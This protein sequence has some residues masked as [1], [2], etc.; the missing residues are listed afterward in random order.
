MSTS[1]PRVVALRGA[2]TVEQDTPSAIEEASEELV[3][4]LLERNGTAP[5]ELISL[6]FTVTPD[7][8]SEFP[9]AAARKMG[10][11]QVPLLCCNEIAVPGAL[12]RCIRV[13]ATLYTSRAASDLQHAYLRDA[14]VLRSDLA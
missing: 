5:E 13:L 12:Q 8:T 1:Q 11:D 4:E 9:A 14:A 7:L 6:I 3:R 2:T 10:L